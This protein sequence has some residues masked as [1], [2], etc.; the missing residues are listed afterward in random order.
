MEVRSQPST[1]GSRILL[2]AAV[3]AAATAMSARAG[4]DVLLVPDSGADRIWAL[5]PF[6]GSIL[7]TDFVPADGIMQQPIQAIPS[8]RGTILVTDELAK[9]VFEY[10]GTGR[11]LRTIADNLEN[12]YAICMKDGFAF[13]TSGF[14]TGGVG[15][16]IYRCSLDGAPP[17]VF[18]DWTGIGDPRGIQPYGD[19]FLVGNSL[20]DDLEI[21]AADGTVA[22]TPF[23]DSDGVSSFDFPQQL[24]DIGNGNWM[25]TGFSRPSGVYF[26]DA[27]AINYA[28]YIAELVTIPRGSFL[29]DNGDLLY[30]GGTRIERL[31]LK[32][33]ENTTIFN[34]SGPSFRWIN[35]FTPPPPCAG[36]I[37]GD[38]AVA[39]SD[40]A[41]LLGAWGTADT[42]ADLDG[43]GTV[44]AADLAALLAAWGPCN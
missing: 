9:A 38:G 7:D 3:I 1:P 11:Y 27:D 8:G 41:S 30:T 43:D 29:L 23:F 40:L 14:S 42:A 2:A 37:D 13:V 21:V 12:C 17:Q 5:S 31:D 32:T 44:T 4:S 20:D 10:S 22:A 24:T 25:L 26:F 6:D 15:G 35:R 34:A 39:A 28:S 33:Y 36:D 19:G 18:S 16:K